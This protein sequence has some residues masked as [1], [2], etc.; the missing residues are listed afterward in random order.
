M[1]FQR[2]E[3]KMSSDYFGLC[4]RCYKTDGYINIGRGQWYYCVKH[5]TTWYPGWNVCDSWRSQTLE[6]QQA[7]YAAMD[8]DSYQEVEP[9]FPPRRLRDRIWSLYHR[10]F[11]SVYKR[12]ARIRVD[13]TIPF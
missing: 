11:W 6:D 2:K 4:P 7:I 13:D 3:S 5:R 9:Y 12:V 10:V 8:F 1:N